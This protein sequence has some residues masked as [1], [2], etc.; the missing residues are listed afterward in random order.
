GALREYSGEHW[1]I[2]YDQAWRDAYD[3]MAGQMLESS[4]RDY[5]QPAFWAAEVVA[6]DRR[7]R[8]VAV[9]QV[10]PVEPYPFRAGQYLHLEAADHP[11]EWRPYSIAN[12][13][14]ADGILELHVRDRDGWVSAAVV[15]RTQPGDVVRLGPPVGMMAIDP[16]STRDV[17]CV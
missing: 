5:H 12:A 6:H 9:M 14:R 2:E 13:P 11:R 15:R 7:G 16:R 17:V 1:C 8:D 3:A 10:R 4:E